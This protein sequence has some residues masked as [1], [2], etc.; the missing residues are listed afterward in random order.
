LLLSALDLFKKD[1]SA[2]DAL[3]FIDISKPL[4]AVVLSQNLNMYELW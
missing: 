4:L 2:D 3:F 1:L